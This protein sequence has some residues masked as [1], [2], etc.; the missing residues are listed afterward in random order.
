[1]AGQVR[2]LAVLAAYP[3]RENIGSW[4]MTHEMLRA[5]V[6]RG[7]SADVVL[8]G[9]PGD[10]YELDGVRVWPHTGPRDAWRFVRDANVIVSHVDAGSGASTI[11]QMTGVPMVAVCHNARPET[12]MLL[13]SRPAALLVF[14]SNSTAAKLGGIHPAPGIVVRPP[15]R[16]E[17]YTAVPGDCITLVNLS[18]D[19]GAGT[20][21]ELAVRFPDRKF[22][23]VIGGYGQQ[24]VRTDPPNVQILE[25][26]PAGRMRD[27]VYARTRVLLM[28]S[29]HES[30]GRTAVEAMH[31]GIPVL[32]S[33]T[34]GLRESLGSAGFFAPHGD[35]DAWE[36]ELRALLDGRRW[37]AAS[38]RALAR[39][40]Q[41][42]P[43]EDLDRW[44]AAVEDIA[45]R[46]PTREGRPKHGRRA[47]AAHHATDGGAP[48]G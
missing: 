1:V 23:G 9:Q 48:A 13:R 16:A 29:A 3:P 31:S 30:Y 28:P 45:S 12:V 42:D 38:R 24:I 11:T 39:A 7:H 17:D 35:V 47:V 37:R 41:I 46:R 19:K 32:A 33:P 27:D 44:C 21:Y 34:P 20:F 25:H 26:V 8:T 4:I 2:V 40:A 36:R 10:P 15:V 22:L 5:L 43:A 18:A 6:A 14:N